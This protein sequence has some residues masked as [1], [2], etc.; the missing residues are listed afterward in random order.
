MDFLYNVRGTETSTSINNNLIIHFLITW[1]V[2][3]EIRTRCAMGRKRPVSNAIWRCK[4]YAI[5]KRRIN[6]TISSFLKQYALHDTFEM[7]NV[8]KFALIFNDS[9]APLAVICKALHVPI[10]IS[11]FASQFPPIFTIISLH[12]LGFIF[13]CDCY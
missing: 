1:K 5:C 3:K 2:F 13:C 12:F 4:F 6:A 9:D 8:S 10:E 11:D 7:L